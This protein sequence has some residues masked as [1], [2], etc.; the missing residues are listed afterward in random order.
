MSENKTKE[1]LIQAVKITGSVV[2]VVL[3]YLLVQSYVLERYEMLSDEKMDRA[4]ESQ[5]VCEQMQEYA[6]ESL[7]FHKTSKY[8]LVYT[9]GVKKEGMLNVLGAITFRNVD[10]DQE[11]F[12]IISEGTGCRAEFLE[13]Y[14]KYEISESAGFIKQDFEAVIKKLEKN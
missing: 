8:E 6:L 14:K 11:F 4:L 10:L 3:G 13:L 2:I 5:G 12:K 7:S 9:N 1:T